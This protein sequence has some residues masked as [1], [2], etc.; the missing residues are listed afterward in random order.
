M[1]QKFRKNGLILLL[2]LIC[3]VAKS[4]NYCIDTVSGIPLQVIADENIF[5]DSWTV[6]PISGRAES[7]DSAEFERTKEIF[8]K[9]LL[10]YP[11][12]VLQ[13]N[14]IRVY[15]FKYLE[16]YG[17]E[18]GGT[19][20]SNAVYMTNDGIENGY[21][22]DYVER[23]FHHEFSNILMRNYPEYLDKDAWYKLNG[24]DFSYG[25]G[26]V[27]ALL[28]NTSSSEFDSIY[29]NSGFLTQY[30]VSAFEEDFNT[31][32]EYLFCPKYEI[33]EIIKNYESIRMKFDITIKFYEQI[34]PFFSK[35][36]FDSIIY[37]DPVYLDDSE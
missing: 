7:L 37:L 3:S 35:D 20:S 29:N 4:Q 19:S 9:A 36:F 33:K 15:A 1:A 28:N 30:S 16:F 17:T 5:P 23:V 14:I 21:S 22:D 31:M 27:D 26:G 34:D 18:Y 24:P 25:T 12:E 2:V 6:S 32:C 11:E 8:R 10:K 13:K